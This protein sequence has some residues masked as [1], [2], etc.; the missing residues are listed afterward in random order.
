MLIA[1]VSSSLFSVFWS[2]IGSK[3]G[4]FFFSLG[5]LICSLSLLL[6]FDFSDFGFQFLVNFGKVRFGIDGVSLSLILLTT[7]LTPLLLILGWKLDRFYFFLFLVLQTFLLVIFSVLDLLWFYIFFEGVLIPMFLVIGIWGSRERKIQAAY[8]FFL[9]TLIGSFFMLCGILYL[10]VIYGTLDI[11]YLSYQVFG[12]WEERILW[13]LFFFS[14]AVKIPLF[15]FHIWLPEAHVE[16]PTAGSVVLAGVLLK[17]GVFGLYRISL[18]LFPEGSNYYSPFLFLLATLSVIYISL[19]ALRQVDL[20]KVIA[21]SS[22]AHMGMVVY[23]LFSGTFLGVVGSLVTLVSHGFISSGLFLLVGFLYDRHKTRSLKYYRGMSSS[24]PLYS[25]LKFLFVLANMGFPLTSGFVG[26]IL[27][28]AGLIQY[29]IVLAFFAS[30]GIILGTVYM[31]W[32][33]S[34][35]LFGDITVFFRAFYDLTWRD[36]CLIFPLA[37]GVIL[38]GVLPELWIS[39]VTP[40]VIR[41]LN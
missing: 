15:P 5:P 13:I 11:E 36:S 3:R 35:I 30:L 33:M 25:I 27:V 8:Q 28:V 14:F 19:T 6:Q 20:K 39:L 21:Y 41:I 40:S 31:I 29:Q 10:W 2:L 23:G 26:E 38:F 34:R 1:L 4:S 32:Y 22:V 9:Y 16:A 37:L 24:M 7:F 18:S 12:L 17:L